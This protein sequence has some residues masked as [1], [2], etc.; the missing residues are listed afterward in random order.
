[1]HA[2][3][4]IS[5]CWCPN[6]VSFQRLSS[7]RHRW[8]TWY[9]S[10]GSPPSWDIGDGFGYPVWGGI[11]VVHIFVLWVMFSGLLMIFLL[12]F[13]FDHCIVWREIYVFWLPLWYLQS[14]SWDL[15]STSWTILFI[16]TI[17]QFTLF[18][19]VNSDNYYVNSTIVFTMH[20]LIFTGYVMFFCRYT[21]LIKYKLYLM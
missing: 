11:S 8:R 17:N 16:S 1:M 14:F 18:L 20:S 4:L 19:V 6:M 7:L 2:H 13:S 15:T 3:Q 10:K 9:H 5:D 21:K 12:T